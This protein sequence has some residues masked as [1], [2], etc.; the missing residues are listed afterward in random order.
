[1]TSSIDIKLSNVV[2]QSESNNAIIP[3]PSSS[4]VFLAGSHVSSL[5]A[6]GIIPQP[7]FTKQLFPDGHPHIP[8]SSLNVI[9]CALA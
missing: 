5:G 7:P 2:A 4:T 6:G 8:Q 1:M 3:S 9:A